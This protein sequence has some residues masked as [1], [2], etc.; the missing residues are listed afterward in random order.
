M[1]RPS[2]EEDRAKGGRVAFIN[3]HTGN[4]ELWLV[5]VVDND[6]G[7]TEEVLDDSEV[8]QDFPY[9]G[10]IRQG[11]R[12]H[13]VERVK[14][15]DIQLRVELLKFV[16]EAI[17]FLLV[18]EVHGARILVVKEGWIEFERVVHALK[19]VVIVFKTTFK[20]DIGNGAG[21]VHGVLVEE[22]VL[23]G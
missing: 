21:S 13:E 20:L 18:Q 11:A 3:E 22:R 4:I 12:E 23:R 17:G 9:Y 5:R 15:Q 19:A 2:V 7:A 16:A 8:A 10:I 14:D 6:H 1:V